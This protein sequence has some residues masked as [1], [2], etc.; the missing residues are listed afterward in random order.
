SSIILN[1]DEPDIR[2]S[3][4]DQTSSALKKLVG[5]HKLIIIDEAQRVKNIGLTLKLLLDNYPDHQLIVTGSSA[6]ELSNEINEPLT[7]RKFEYNLHPLSMFELSQ[8][9]SLVEL[10]RVLNYRVIY[11]MYPE[12]TQ[13]EE[14]PA[15]LLKNL[16]TSYLYKDIFSF[17]DIRKPEILEK[18][19]RLLAW[20]IGNLVSYQELANSLGV[21]IK[22]VTNYIDLLEKTFVIFKLTPYNR[23]LRNELTKM[24]KIYFYD[25][26]IRNAIISDFSFIENRNDKGE[27]WENFLISERIKF[28]A[29][30]DNFANTFFWRTKQQQEIDWIEESQG[31]LNAFEIKWKKSNRKIPRTFTNAYPD[32]KVNIV[33]NGNYDEFIG[34]I[35]MKRI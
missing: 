26:G 27:L 3:L 21:D 19:L 1:C 29:H 30:S 35:Y 5:I 25:T 11:G 16:A 10:K 14:N 12:I 33:N 7:G 23:N 24:R 17:Q 6:L 13:A 31:K 32:S 4:T 28:N 8:N 9:T 18:L 2:E 20:Q 15:E 22:T 34:L